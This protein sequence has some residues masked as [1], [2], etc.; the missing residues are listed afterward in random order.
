MKLTVDCVMCEKELLPVF[1][2]MNGEQIHNQ[3]NGGIVFTSTGNYGSVVFDPFDGTAVSINI[4]DSCFR[5]AVN[6][7]LVVLHNTNGVDEIMEEL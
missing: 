2:P 4:C 5:E 7:K 1:V 6:K 3:P